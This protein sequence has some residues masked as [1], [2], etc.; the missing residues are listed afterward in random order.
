MADASGPPVIRLKISRNSDHPWIYRRMVAKEAGRGVD[1]GSVVRVEDRD[2]RAVGQAFWNPR[3]EIAL[4]LLSTDATVRVDRAFFASA[5][6]RAVS[7]RHDVLRLPETTDAYRLVN[8]EADGLSGLV[9]DRYADAIVLELYS[10]G[11]FEILEDLEVIFGELFPGSTF[12]VRS[13]WKIEKIEGFRTHWKQSPSR[14]VVV[15]ENG[16]RFHVDLAL[17]HKTGFFLDQRDNRYFLGT[18]ARGRSVLDCF[19]YT[20]GFALHAAKAGAAAV[21]A[22]DLDEKAIAV[23]RGNAELNGAAVNFIHSDV[24]PFLRGLEGKPPAHDVI[25][26]DPTKLAHSKED[27]PRASRAYM[28]MNRLA[29]AVIRPEGILVSCSCSG[30]LSEDDFLSILRRAARESRR[31]LEVFRVAG[32]GG[33]HPVAS[34]CPEGR[35]LKVV[36]SRVRPL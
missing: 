3:S 25:V 32:A 16:V 24:F 4:R 22:V 11:Y 7:L 28:D 2:G 34:S 36:F 21:T 27:L 18:L 5:I 15:K 9:A 1:P 23:A 13:D 33:D 10:A 19:C 12:H 29:M 20:G 17:G 8:S 6:R 35:Y 26:L 31:E 14:S 30:K